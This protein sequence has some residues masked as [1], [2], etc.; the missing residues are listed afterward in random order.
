[1][2]NI[3]KILFLALTSCF[4]ACSS[5]QG[6]LI[7]ARDYHLTSGVGGD[8]TFAAFSALRG[9]LPAGLLTKNKKVYYLTLPSDK[10]A[11]YATDIIRVEGKRNL[12]KNLL[13]PKKVYVKKNRTWLQIYT[14][15]Y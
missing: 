9:N 1:M 4:C 6:T 3:K 10:L 15:D 12:S 7:D 14:N 5:I 8:H 11:P 2:K 13:L